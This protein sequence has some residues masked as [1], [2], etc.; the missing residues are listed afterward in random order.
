MRRRKRKRPAERPAALPSAP[1]W[2]KWA[3]ATETDAL[4]FLYE[5]G[6][7]LRRQRRYG[8][9]P[10]PR[11][12]PRA[13]WGDPEVGWHRSWALVAAGQLWADPDPALR[14][15]VRVLV[16]DRVT[17]RMRYEVLG[18]D[19]VPFRKATVPVHRFLASGYRLVRSAP[20]RRLP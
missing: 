5:V 4:S 6:Y 12:V 11:P 18:S 17:Q 16:V 8:P 10:L 1:W 15:F 7:E 13:H 2:R 19:G 20:I 14:R 9:D 3:F